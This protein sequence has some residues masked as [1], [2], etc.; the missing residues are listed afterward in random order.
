MTDT[1][2]TC[3]RPLRGEEIVSRELAE[4]ALGV[5]GRCIPADHSG[6]DADEARA[7]YDELETVLRAEC[8]DCEGKGRVLGRASDGSY[9]DCDCP[10]CRGTGRVPVEEPCPYCDGRGLTTASPGP[11]EAVP[12]WLCHGTGR[13]PAEVEGDG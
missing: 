7:V 13:A 8:P 2:P 5:I 11:S 3:H 12:C 9:F 1:C 10:A 4:R 6:Y